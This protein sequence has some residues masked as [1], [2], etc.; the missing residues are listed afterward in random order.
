MPSFDIIVIGAGI[1]G[2]SFAYKI[3]KYAKT[4]L[5]EARDKKCL[6]MTTNI[7][8]EHNRRFLR[9]DEVD[10]LNKSIFPCN[11]RKINYMDKKYH[12][13][14][15]SEE[16]GED[17]GYIS[18][19][20][21][22]I[23]YL[24][25]KSE[26]QGNTVKY[27]EKILKVLRSSD[28]IEI[29]SNKGESYV[30]KLLAIATGSGGFDLQR[31]LGF[32]TPDSYMGVYKHL[33][34]KED[35]LQENLPTDYIFHINPKI[36]HDG[37]FFFNR[38]RERI[39][40]GFLGKKDDTSE[41][42]ISKFY[43][44]LNNYNEIQPFIKDLKKDET[45]PVIGKISKHPIKNLS[46]NRSLVLGEA[47]GLV[48]AFFYEG[49]LGGLASADIATSVIKPL[50]E[51]DSNF[52]QAELGKYDKELKRILLDTYFKTGIASEYL[53]YHSGTKLNTLWEIYCNFIKTN[54]TIRRYIWEAIRKHDLENYDLQ[55]DK[56][57]GE[58]L[59][60][61][62]PVLSK[63]TYWPLFLKAMLK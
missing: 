61:K 40:L 38:G 63:M 21:N 19:T 32:E 14:I 26:E 29:I 47:G 44:I 46:L 34:G 16:F 62:L 27:N 3:S 45:E 53:F 13:I 12:G 54:K 43:R 18:Y 41:A 37:P 7:F 25:Q 5:V 22:L 52:T 23:K 58:Q 60:K 4:L 59:F 35:Q 20:E 9:D 57:T 1:S 31:S 42:I 8:P 50:L 55:R 33:F 39:S 56:W 48:T 49:I 24:L 10:Y 30:G 6:P 17:F 2:A 28:K 15:H 51:E 11:F 36:S